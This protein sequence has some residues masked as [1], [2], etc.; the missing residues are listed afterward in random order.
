MPFE[1]LTPNAQANAYE[2]GLSRSCL[3]AGTK[4]TCQAIQKEGNNIWIKIPSG[5]VAAFYNGKDYIK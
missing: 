3:K 2:K 4:V 1:R 5:W